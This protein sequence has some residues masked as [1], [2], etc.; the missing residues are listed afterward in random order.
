MAKPKRIDTHFSFLSRGKGGVVRE[1]LVFNVIHLVR[2]WIGKERR[3]FTK[4]D[5]FNVLN[6]NTP[7]NGNYLTPSTRFAD[8]TLLRCVAVETS[9]SSYTDSVGTYG[10]RRFSRRSNNE[11]LAN[12]QNAMGAVLVKSHRTRVW[13]LR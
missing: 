11:K 2:R 8:P 9:G 12:V 10:S 1:T 3:P 7:T 4:S 6:N 5:G 13:F